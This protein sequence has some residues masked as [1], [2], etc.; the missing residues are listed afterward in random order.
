MATSGGRKYLAEGFLTADRYTGSHEF[1]VT[2]GGSVET[3]DRELSYL[4]A[5]GFTSPDF[6]HPNNASKVTDYDGTVWS[7]NLI[8]AFGRLNYRWGERFVV[9][10]VS[11]DGQQLSGHLMTETPP[12]LAVYSLSDATV[13]LARDVKLAKGR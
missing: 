7:H 6:H 9:T 1:T 10:A 11:S 8:S 3:N 2:A 12:A 13:E 5:E 4:F